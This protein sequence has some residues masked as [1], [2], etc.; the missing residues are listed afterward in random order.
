V[1][2][3][4]GLLIGSLFIR[5]HQKL[6][7]KGICLINPAM[8]LSNLKDEFYQ[9]V[10][11]WYTGNN[12]P[13]DSLLSPIK[14][15]NFRAFPPTLIITCEKDELK[16]QGIALYEKLQLNGI[17]VEMMDIPNEDHL[18]PFWAA[19]HPLAKMATDKAIAFI[20]SQSK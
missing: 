4:G 17:K 2:R 6:S 9:L 16:A 7:V 1:T 11:N 12:N 5:L 20:L 14:A 8:D 19:N 3:G 18:G 15:T 13:N 10:S